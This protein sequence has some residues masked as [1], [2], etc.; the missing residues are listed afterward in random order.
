MYPRSMDVIFATYWFYPAKT[1]AILPEDWKCIEERM[2]EE[3]IR[4]DPDSK[5][6]FRMKLSSMML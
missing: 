4:F 6:D 3:T 5:F 1:K 2:Q